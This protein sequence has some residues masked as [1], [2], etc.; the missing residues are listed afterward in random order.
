MKKDVS[1][2]GLLTMLLVLTKN[3][4][5]SS[6]AADKVMSNNSLFESV[7]KQELNMSDM[8]LFRLF[9]L[10]EQWQDGSNLD[11]FNFRLEKDV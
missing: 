3:C 10:C 4:K 9:I 1:L 6:D 5:L 8:D 2:I 11:I 7:V